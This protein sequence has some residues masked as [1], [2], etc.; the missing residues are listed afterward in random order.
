MRVPTLCKVR[1][2]W[3]VT[4]SVTVSSTTSVRQPEL[5]FTASVCA[6]QLDTLAA[7]NPAQSVALV[8]AVTLDGDNAALPTFVAERCAPCRITQDVPFVTVSVRASQPTLV[9]AP[10]F[11]RCAPMPRVSPAVA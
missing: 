1:R 8:S 5:A 10:E 6:A 3:I 2:P 9:L 7:W 11:G 4:G